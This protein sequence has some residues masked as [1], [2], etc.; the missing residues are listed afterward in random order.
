MGSNLYKTNTPTIVPGYKIKLST[1]VDEIALSHNLSLL[2][3]IDS[4]DY[5][6]NINDEFTLN[7]KAIDRLSA[8]DRKDIVYLVENNY[9]A[10]IYMKFKETSC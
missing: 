10:P 1:D 6:Y 9:L 8:V 3:K 7:K 5:E 2:Q 4:K